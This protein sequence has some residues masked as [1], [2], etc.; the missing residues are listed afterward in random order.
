MEDIHLELFCSDERGESVLHQVV[1][2]GPLDGPISFPC[3]I[4]YSKISRPC[5]S[6]KLGVG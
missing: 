2:G 1:E 6:K 5:R 4:H 3:R